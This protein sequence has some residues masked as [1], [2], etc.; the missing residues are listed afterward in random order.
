MLAG[1]IIEQFFDMNEQLAGTRANWS[2]S[3]LEP[4]DLVA[5]QRAAGA[6]PGLQLHARRAQPAERCIY[7]DMIVM[8]HARRLHTNLGLGRAHHSRAP[9]LRALPKDPMYPLHT[10]Q[11]L[12]FVYFGLVWLRGPYPARC[13]RPP[14]A[15]SATVPCVRVTRIAFET[16]YPRVARGP[17]EGRTAFFFAPEA[18][19]V[20]N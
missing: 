19:T 18:H 9:A 10:G 5:S 8:L 2:C 3:F 6:P 12:V 11:Y 20:E 17:P 13:F 15:A 4:I 1:P 14:R 16:S 7:A